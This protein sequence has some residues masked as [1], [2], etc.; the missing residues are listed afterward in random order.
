[1]P[2]VRPSCSGL[3]QATR[4]SERPAG[5][6]WPPARPRGPRASSC[7]RW[8]GM[9]RQDDQAVRMIRDAEFVGDV[10]AVHAGDTFTRVR[11]W[12]PNQPMEE[13]FGLEPFM[14]SGGKH[15]HRSSLEAVQ[16]CYGARRPLDHRQRPGSP[17]MANE[18][19]TA[20]TLVATN[21]ATILPEWLD[22]QR[23]ARCAAD[24]AHHRGGDQDAIAGFPASAAR[25]AHQRRQ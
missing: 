5:R 16:N 17:I 13:Q 4:G 6:R 15:E 19:G 9:G 23:K 12:P 11:F 1:M 24:R 14:G 21:E 18:P 8:L 7:D 3:R 22:L 20:A 10:D 2:A 25:R